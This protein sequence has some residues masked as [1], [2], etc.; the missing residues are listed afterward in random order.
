MTNLIQVLFF[1]CSL[2]SCS[3]TKSVQQEGT[4][5]SS[6]VIKNEMKNNDPVGT[7]DKTVINQKAYFTVTAGG[8]QM[9]NENGEAVTNFTIN[10][11]VILEFP[12]TAKPEI[13]SI[14]YN[15]RTY[16]AA[17]T[18]SQKNEMHPGKTFSSGSPVTVKANKNNNLWK[19]EVS[20]ADGK[21]EAK[22]AQKNIII[23]GLQNNK[24]FTIQIPAEAELQAEMMY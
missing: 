16:T 4:K 10:R 2:F 15:S 21:E 22:T 13:N 5:D 19:I 18:A 3:P 14:K 6:I 9:V 11:F 1:T 20:P 17:S 23:K 8:T 12:G 7:E 24:P